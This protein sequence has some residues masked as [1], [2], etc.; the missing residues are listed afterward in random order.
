MTGLVGCL[1]L[2]G[3]PCLQGLAERPRRRQLHRLPQ[4]VIAV[5]AWSALAGWAGPYVL[6]W[7]SLVSGTRRRALVDHE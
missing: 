7:R 6:N 1:R 3:E 5:F 2:Q 4:E